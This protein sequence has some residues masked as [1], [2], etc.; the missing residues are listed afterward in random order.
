MA[1]TSPA[2][3]S[4]E[5][6]SV[7]G[8]AGSASAPGPEEGEPPEPV[9]VPSPQPEPE[10][11]YA[12]PSRHQP[13]PAGSE[14]EHRWATKVDGWWQRYTRPSDI[15]AYEAEVE[16]L[17]KE[18]D[19]LPGRQEAEHDKAEQAF[20]TAEAKAKEIAALMKAQLESDE[21]VRTQDVQT[22][23]ENAEEAKATQLVQAD[24]KKARE[25]DRLQ[26]THTLRLADLDKL[27]APTLEAA[28]GPVLEKIEQLKEAEGLSLEKSFGDMKQALIEKRDQAN[29]K[30]EQRIVEATAQKDAA[31]KELEA[32]HEEHSSQLDKL[33]VKVQ[34]LNGAWDA[35]HSTARSYK[36]DEVQQRLDSFETDREYLSGKRE[37]AKKQKQ[38]RIELAEEDKKDKMQKL[39]SQHEQ[40]VSQLDALEAMRVELDT[41]WD[42]A[43][44]AVDGFTKEEE[45]ILDGKLSHA[46]RS[47]AKEREEAK[48]T[49]EGQ[50]TARRYAR[51]TTLQKLEDR[52]VERCR[53]LDKQLGVTAMESHLRMLQQQNDGRL[54]WLEQRHDEVS[55]LEE[56]KKKLE[57]DYDK[58]TEPLGKEHDRLFEKYATEEN[59][60]MQDLVDLV[61]APDASYCKPTLTPS[62]SERGG[63]SKILSKLQE[64]RKQFDEDEAK[65]DAKINTVKAKIQAAEV[66]WPRRLHRTS[67]PERREPKKSADDGWQPTSEELRLIEAGDEVALNEKAQGLS[68]EMSRDNMIAAKDQ[69]HK[70]HDVFSNPDGSTDDQDITKTLPEIHD[71]VLEWQKEFKD[72]IPGCTDRLRELTDAIKEKKEVL[73]AQ[74]TKAQ[75]KATEDF[76]VAHRQSETKLKQE[77]RRIS[78]SEANAQREHEEKLN[79][80]KTEWDSFEAAKG[81]VSDADKKQLQLIEMVFDNDDAQIY[82]V[83]TFVREWIDAMV[84]PRKQQWLDRNIPAEIVN[85][86][87]RS[88]A[89]S[90]AI[91]D[92]TSTLEKQKTKAEEQAEQDFEEAKRRSETELE[93]AER[94]IRDSE[95][96]AEHEHEEKLASLKQYWDSFETAKGEVSDA[97]KKQLQLIDWD[98]ED[99]AADGASVAARKIQMVCVAA[100]D[101]ADAMVE[102]RKQQWLD[103]NIP[104]E[105]VNG[106]ARSKALSKAI[107][108]KTSTLEKQKTKAEEQA[109]QDFEEAKRRSGTE[110]EQAERSISESE[111]LA[112]REHEE[113]LN[114]R[115][116]YWDSFETAK[117]EVSDADKKQLQQ[118]KLVFDDDDDRPDELD[119]ESLVETRTAV[120][121]WVACANAAA[122]ATSL[123]VGTAV[124]WTGVS[125]DVPE[126]T[127]GEIVGVTQDGKKC[128]RF[129]SV[130]IQLLEPKQLKLS[131]AVPSTAKVAAAEEK[132]A[133]TEENPWRDLKTNA[134]IMNGRARSKALLK[135]VEDR[136]K[137][138]EEQKKA[139][140]GAAN[141]ACEEAK[142]KAHSEC[143]HAKRD[144][145]EQAEKHKHEYD[146]NQVQVKQRKEDAV[147]EAQA[148]QQSEKTR[149]DRQFESLR[150]TLHD[151][152]SRAGEDLDSLKQL[153]ESASSL[154]AERIAELIKEIKALHKKRQEREQKAQSDIASLER[155]D[156]E[157]AKGE[158][159]KLESEKDQKLAELQAEIDALDGD[160]K[161][162]LD[163]LALK[164]K[165]LQKHRDDPTG[166]LEEEIKAVQVAYSE[167]LNE[168]RKGQLGVFKQVK[169]GNAP[170]PAEVQL[171]ETFV[172][173]ATEQLQKVV[174]LK[175]GQKLDQERLAA[176]ARALEETTQT[177]KAQQER[178]IEDAK[179]KKQEEEAHLTAQIAVREKHLQQKRDDTK[180]RADQRQK[181]I[182]SYLQHDVSQLQAETEQLEA[183]KQRWEAKSLD[184]IVIENPSLQAG[185]AGDTPIG[186][187]PLTPQRRSR[188]P[189]TGGR[190]PRTS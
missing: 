19:G 20:Q 15:A 168:Y 142:R 125:D 113:K 46:K 161:R 182:D 2:A 109:E 30:H 60:C 183:E 126:G 73:E 141:D 56:K 140:E 8:I 131:A 130:A 39:V 82:D 28:F 188:T 89:L 148:T 149:I 66:L 162:K 64:L 90:K 70:L 166:A 111:A 65:I 105:I 186:M 135:A 136:K 134:E 119:A 92:K 58:K 42:T 174:G 167:L 63:A 4:A 71:A 43:H 176:H 150:N 104:A 44:R 189:S 177:Y 75:G 160:F 78:E 95:K 106:R 9:P 76:K 121:E 29:K 157:S 59:A 16:G 52:H 93:H 165:E 88:K 13:A 128:V 37:D 74:K 180:K 53:Q 98:E 108:D 117:G 55:K 35:A 143:E 41:A 151:L 172:K 1:S 153:T 3:A 100:Q 178:K 50:I 7:P 94:S 123:Y 84:E 72:D 31:A 154:R 12:T 45:R 32:R 190:S 85:G 129:P 14:E 81:E 127:V 147:E 138:L 69:L 145:D 51:E 110:L 23:L 114:D 97:D 99:V 132:V 185:G 22:Q 77:E 38:R 144:I 57:Q 139:K 36:E 181:L 26:A 187:G 107:A 169:A 103:R 115:K 112:E 34:V 158:I 156:G 80:L 91:A 133:E 102:P 11:E 137:G 33:G 68:Y 40:H 18:F 155:D 17:S 25:M 122:H 179:S 159:A 173:D 79:D 120:T 83:Y 124:T 170:D 5:A 163:E 21:A 10:P 171:T 96:L 184:D 146:M 48:K 54:R 175:G 61:E 152:L 116:E 6:T 24:E 62:Q 49:S 27:G 87:A 67:T 86:R 164:L 47:L 101:W 118:I